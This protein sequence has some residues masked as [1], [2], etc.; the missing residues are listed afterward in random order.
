[1]TTQTIG[2]AALAKLAEAGGN[3][4]VSV[5]ADKDGWTVCVHDEAGEYVLAGQTGKP[6]AVFD[7]LEAV[8]QHLRAVGIVQFEVDGRMDRDSDDPAYDAWFKAQV[9]EAL[10]DP[11]PS[12]PHDEAMRMLRAATELNNAPSPNLPAKLSH[13]GFGGGY[14]R[15]RVALR[16]SEEGY[17]VSVPAL[18]GCSSQGETEEEAIDNI[19]IAIE[20]YL[21]VLEEQFHDTDVK[22][23][24]VTV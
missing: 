17:S 22:E 9:R 20:E 18:P 14:M 16:K 5:L 4:S 2:P 23:V 24:E 12:I 11:S 8:E 19:K 13:D 15:Y 7:A 1:M 6:T 21:S 3:F 10:N